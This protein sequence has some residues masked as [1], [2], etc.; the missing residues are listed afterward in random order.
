MTDNLNTKK[1][2]VLIYCLKNLIDIYTRY[3]DLVAGGFFKYITHDLP[4]INSVL[5]DEFEKRLLEF[6]KNS[7]PENQI[8]WET[9]FKTFDINHICNSWFSKVRP[10][11]QVMK[12]R[13]ETTVTEHGQSSLPPEF[14]TFTNK[15][16]KMIT[17]Y[18]ILRNKYD[19]TTFSQIIKEK[20]TIQTL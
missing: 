9:P 13:I 3:Y 20:V 18:E 10:N 5:N 1:P 8:Q 6:N 2:A 19:A 12:F 11:L 14:M 17:E 15:L 16:E 7:P 4:L